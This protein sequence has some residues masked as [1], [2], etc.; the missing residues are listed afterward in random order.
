VILRVDVVP[1]P[2]WSPLPYEGCRDVDGK[3]LVSQ[4]DLLVALL[5]FAPNGTIH[6]H[7]GEADCIVVCLEG[8]GYVS[9]GDEVAPL[10]AGER[11]GWQPGEVHRLWT[12]G[13]TMTT[14]MVERPPQ[15]A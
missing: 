8:H 12:E 15:L 14:L 9:I 3:V 2:E 6:E 10:S 7:A 11:T 1:R 4:P 13:S 5:R